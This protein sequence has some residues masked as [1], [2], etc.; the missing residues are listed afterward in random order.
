[1]IF[2]AT[3]AKNYEVAFN[4]LSTKIMMKCVKFLLH[5]QGPGL[6]VLALVKETKEHFPEANFDILHDL[7]VVASRVLQLPDWGNLVFFDTEEHRVTGV[8]QD[9]AGIP[10]L[11][12][13]WKIIH[14]FKPTEGLLVQDHA[15]SLGITVGRVQLVICLFP[16]SP[17]T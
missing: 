3:V 11:G 4:D 13:S 5:T 2:T 9:L 8:R 17:T 1:M 12:P 7:R 14:D 16:P 15:I 6:D 10:K